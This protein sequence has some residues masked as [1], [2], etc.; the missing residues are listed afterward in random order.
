MSS[1]PARK[2]RSLLLGEGSS[3][4]QTLT[5]ACLHHNNTGSMSGFI[6]FVHFGRC[7][8]GGP[9]RAIKTLASGGRALEEAEGETG[10]RSA[11]GE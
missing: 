4:C 2:F 3:C 10:S 7:R 11:P 1:R 5:N 9:Q 6:N 8:A